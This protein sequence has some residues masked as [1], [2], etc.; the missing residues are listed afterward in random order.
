MNT[1]F[2]RVPS[3]SQ[4]L[5]STHQLNTKR[6]LLFSPQNRV[7]ISSTQTPSVQHISSTEAPKI[8]SSKKPHLFQHPKSLSFT[9]KTPQFNTKKILV[10]HSLQFHTKNPSVQRQN[11][12]SSIHLFSSLI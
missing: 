3:V 10:Q 1:V 8:L 7:S 12:L 11:P 4:S 6:P 9:P 5:S 2:K